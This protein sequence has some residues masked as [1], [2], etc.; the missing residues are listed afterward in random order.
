MASASTFQSTGFTL[1]ALTAIRFCLGL[2]CLDYRSDMPYAHLE[3][4][5]V[6]R[7]H[8]AQ[9]AHERDHV[10]HRAVRQA[11]HVDEYPAASLREAGIVPAWIP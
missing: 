10:P 11:R 4:Q 9:L 2:A 3:R 6:L 1:A 8:A 5:R 7:L